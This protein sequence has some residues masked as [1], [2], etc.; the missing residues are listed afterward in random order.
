MKITSGCID[1]PPQQIL[2]VAD[3]DHIQLARL[4]QTSSSTEARLRFWSTI[5]TR[6]DLSVMRHCSRTAD[7]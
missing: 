7:Q 2:H 3:H 4:A 5:T 1:D 6:S